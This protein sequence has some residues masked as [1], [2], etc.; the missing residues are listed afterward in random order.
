[1]KTADILHDVEEKARKANESIVKIDQSSGDQ[2]AAI[3]Q[4]KQGLSQVSDVV[5]TNAATAEEN[6]ATSEEMSAQAATLREEVGK[7]KLNSSYEKESGMAI[8]LNDGYVSKKPAAASG[9]Y[10][11]Y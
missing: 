4:M 5:Q 7:F 3:E 8:S 10:G 2:A 1:V 9:R 11:K 6:S